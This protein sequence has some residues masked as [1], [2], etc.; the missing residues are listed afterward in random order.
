MLEFPEVETKTIKIEG[1]DGETKSPE[2]DPDLDSEG[3]DDLEKSG[4]P[5][6]ITTTCPLCPDVKLVSQHKWGKV[7]FGSAFMLARNVKHD[8]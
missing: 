5:K 1:L 4:E 2:F 6:E 3:L 8:I 7:R